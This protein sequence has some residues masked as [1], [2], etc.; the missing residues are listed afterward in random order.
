LYRFCDNTASAFRASSKKAQIIAHI[1]NKWKSPLIKRSKKDTS[2]A[3]NGSRLTLPPDF[4][5]DVPSRE[6]ILQ[7]LRTHSSPIEPQALAAALGASPA[8]VGF[9]RRLKAMERDG[10]ALFN[11]QGQ[12]LLNTKLDFIA[13]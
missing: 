6:A 4:D 9:E 12:L 8:S 5:P 13:G 1:F 11:A 3:E 7:Y 2:N 10:Q